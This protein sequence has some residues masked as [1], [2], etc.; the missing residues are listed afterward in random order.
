MKELL[1][2]LPDRQLS[3]S[4]FVDFINN[5][6]FSDYYAEKEVV[7]S[8]S[9]LEARCFGLIAFYNDFLKQPLEP[10]MLVPCDYKGNVLEEPAQGG[11]LSIEVGYRKAKERVLYKEAKSCTWCV[12]AVKVD[13]M[14]GWEVTQQFWIEALGL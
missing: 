7:Y 8:F 4:D 5:D 12:D 3:L 10:R 9:D 13:K 2:I 6:A 11:M 14:K 1:E